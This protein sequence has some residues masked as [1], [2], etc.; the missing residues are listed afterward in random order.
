M[1]YDQV[2]GEKDGR[3][4]RKVISARILSERTV[5][6]ARASRPESS[7]APLGQPRRAR[8]RGRGPS[9]RPLLCRD[10]S[11]T[12]GSRDAEPTN[13]LAVE[14]SEMTGQR[15]SVAAVPPRLESDHGPIR[16]RPRSHDGNDPSPPATATGAGS[17]PDDLRWRSAT[18]GRPEVDVATSATKAN[19][20][21]S[22]AGRE[23]RSDL[24]SRGHP[25]YPRQRELQPV[26]APQACRRTSR[27][28]TAS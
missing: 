9:R 21:E 12:C 23:R 3:G 8:A 27:E 13:H 25:R 6:R 17:S 19:I 18:G 16:P 1:N 7:S 24:P 14:S 20:A 2:G 22:A 15:I 4:G 26:E 11:S 10:A 5:R 28:T